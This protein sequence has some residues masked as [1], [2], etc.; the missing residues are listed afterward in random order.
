MKHI[1]TIWES[2][3]LTLLTVSVGWTVNLLL[4]DILS[5]TY[6]QYQPYFLS[7]SHTS[8]RFMPT[9]NIA[10]PIISHFWIMLDFWIYH[11]KKLKLGDIIYHIGLFIFCTLIT[12]WSKDCITWVCQCSL[13][14]HHS[15]TQWFPQWRLV[16]AAECKHQAMRSTDQSSPQ[17]TSC[18][19]RGQGSRGECDSGVHGHSS[20]DCR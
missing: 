5:H 20:P 2:L 12:N 9:C 3:L 1:T 17:S 10:I 11:P 7:S 4:Q 13:L 18:R 6:T 8:P 19:V 14:L 16:S 15:Q